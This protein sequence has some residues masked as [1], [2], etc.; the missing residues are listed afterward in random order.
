MGKFRLKIIGLNLNRLLNILN[1]KNIEIFDLERISYNDIELSIQ[2]FNLKETKKYI[3]QNNLRYEILGGSGILYFLRTYWYRFGIVFGL[4]LSIA[5][6][7]IATKYYWSVEVEIDSGNCEVLTQV[8]T[9][10]TEQGI[11]VGEPLKEIESRSL[12]R[13]ILENIEDASIVVVKQQGVSLK[14]FIKEAVKQMNLS[15][16]GIV[17]NFG[18]VIEEIDLVSGSLIVNIGDAVAKGDVLITSGKVGDVFMEAHGSIIA[19]VQIEGDAVGCLE[20]VSEIRTGNCTEVVY[21]EAFGKRFYSSDVTENVAENL[22]GKYQVEKEEV[23]LTQNNLLPIKKIVLRYYEIEEKCVTIDYGQLI[24]QLSASAY[25][26]AK[27]R[28]P[29]GSDELAVSYNTIQEGSL[30]KVVCSIETRVD[31]AKRADN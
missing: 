29:Q 30:H 23:V 22:Y 11:A 18:G 12:E 28:L 13:I 15:E 24:E 1:A 9:F 5:G 27:S 26:I 21:L 14:V 25:N 8:Q 19:R 20:Q 7:I 17:A 6:F 31:I 3:Q 2:S 16:Q 4:L 10:L